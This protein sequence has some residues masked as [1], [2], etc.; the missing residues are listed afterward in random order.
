[1]NSDVYIK[2]INHNA[3]VSTVKLITISWDNTVTTVS[4]HDQIHI[5]LSID[6]IELMVRT[7][8]YHLDQVKESVSI[9]SMFH[10]EREMLKGK[11]LLKSD[12]FKF[13]EQRTKNL[14]SDYANWLMKVEINNFEMTLL[15]DSNNFDLPIIKFQFENFSFERKNIISET[16]PNP[17][18][19]YLIGLNIGID[20][21]NRLYNGY[22][23][24]LEPWK[25]TSNIFVNDDASEHS[26]KVF[27]NTPDLFRINFTPMSISML[28][29]LRRFFFTLCKNIKN[30]DHEY[31]SM[32][33]LKHSK[34]FLL[35]NE[36]GLNLSFMKIILPT[37]GFQNSTFQQ[38][39]QTHWISV[40]KDGSSEFEIECEDFYSG[41][42][43]NSHNVHQ[44]Q[45]QIDGY[46]DV[47]PVT[48][49]KIGTY[50]RHTT[51]LG[52]RTMYDT[53]KTRLVISVAMLGAAQKIV[54][55]RSALCI[56][57]K[58]EYPLIVTF[59]KNIKNS[60]SQER[61]ITE[62]KIILAGEKF[63]VPLK[64]VH[65]SFYFKPQETV[66]N[67]KIHGTESNE[68]K[69]TIDHKI[70]QNED[71]VDN[72]THEFIGPL[73]WMDAAK[74][75]IE[76]IKSCKLSSGKSL[77][78]KIYILK[79][80]FPQQ[81]SFIYPGHI[82]YI[83]PPLLLYNNLPYD[84]LFKLSSIDYDRLLQG[85]KLHIYEIEMSNCFYLYIT[86]DSCPGCAAIKITTENANFTI[87]LI[88]RLGREILINV[89]ITN[90]FGDGIHVKLFSLYWI[91]NRTYLPMVYRQEG[92]MVENAGQY[93]ENEERM[94]SYP[95]LFSC[96]DKE[97]PTALL[98]RLGKIYGFNNPVSKESRLSK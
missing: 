96:C 87:R 57:N 18:V 12:D 4:V 97:K 13:S 88:D 11:C 67:E 44:I 27:L 38:P 32:G 85:K 35:K 80:N 79:E 90:N 69:L 25:L 81:E 28:S 98:I 34:L 91:I 47:G 3:K 17:E 93:S 74:E 22:E 15:D 40:P 82:V 92:S 36:T 26:L 16:S 55:V 76:T 62:Q 23:P 1:M 19:L 54:T 70:Y 72:L 53:H 58:T 9:E 50:F 5:C 78:F 86:L 49:D 51:K 7:I 29:T 75:T 43:L 65:Q 73:N 10:S 33:R 95:C 84:L 31:L 20:L 2:N 48:I 63:P 83:K 37:R 68:Q 94:I 61:S 14:T 89:Q 42:H 8:S 46:N 60:K 6:A 41:I 59:T 24:F 21:Y 71:K 39:D 64:N 30:M 77:K 66:P 52:S 45:I 56:V